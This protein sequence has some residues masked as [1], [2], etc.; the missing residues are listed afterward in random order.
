MSKD[1]DYIIELL[2]EI[3]DEFRELREYFDFM[4]EEEDEDD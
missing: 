4:R 2:V 1:T 3:R